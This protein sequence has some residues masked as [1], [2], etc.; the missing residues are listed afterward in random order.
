MAA[1]GNTIA[2]RITLGVMAVQLIVLPALYFGMVYLF[3]QSNE[4]SFLNNVRGHARFVADSLEHRGQQITD[5]EIENILDSIVLSGTGVYAELLGDSRQ[6][7]S[8]LVSETDFENYREDFGLG[9]HGDNTY[10]FSMPLMLRDSYF[11]LHVGFDESAYL[12]RNAF[13]YRNGLIVVA[14]Y[15]AAML[16]ILPLIGRR[17]T[18]P[19]N[20]LQRAS[21]KIASGSTSESLTV[22]TKIVEIIELTRDLE[23][24]RTR[25][26][27]INRQLQREITEREQA[28]KNRISLERQLQH[29]QRLEAV[30]TM[31][32]GIAHEINNML[33][34]IILYTDTA[35]EDLP[36]SSSIRGDLQRVLRSATRAKNIMS[37]IL[38]F[39][40]KLEGEEERQI[41]FGAIVSDSVEFV[42][43]SKPAYVELGLTIEPDCPPVFGNA[44]L[45]GQVVVN[46]CG[47]AIQAIPSTGGRIEISLGSL[48]VDQHL[49]LKNPALRNQRYLCLTVSDTGAGMDAETI[50]RIFEPFFTTR[51]VGGGTGL[52]LSVVHGIVTRLNGVIDVESEVQSGSSFRVYLPSGVPN[53][54]CQK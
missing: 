26:T 52:G 48:V 35:I 32:G 49:A 27:G 14:I 24:M 17:I 20:A 39:S 51:S 37:Q 18:R 13:A 25:L 34:P 29:S 15:L 6:F 23:L 11:T 50:D 47:N 4:E 8:T 46:L 31:A 7:R 2:S 28:E 41:D 10:Y 30:G 22:E 33:V 1:L 44:S 12:E 9:Q 3:K 36:E 43:A 5:E 42:R 54:A 45:L 16:A 21:R 53:A 38:T 40:R 19:I